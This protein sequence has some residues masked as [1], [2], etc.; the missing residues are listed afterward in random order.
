ME[1]Q[2]FVTI[3]GARP[4]LIKAAVISRLVKDHYPLVEEVMIHTGRHFDINMS[5]IFFPENAI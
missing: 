1:S 5:D 2:K 3:V 4:Q